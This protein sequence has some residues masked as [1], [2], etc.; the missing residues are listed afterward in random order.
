MTTVN[1]TATKKLRTAVVVVLDHPRF[2]ERRFGFS[3]RVVTTGGRA[4]VGTRDGKIVRPAASPTRKRLESPG[5]V[6][7]MPGGVLEGLPAEFERCTQVAGLLASGM[8][9]ISRVDSDDGERQQ[10]VTRT[11]GGARRRASMPAKAPSTDEP[12]EPDSE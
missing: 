2:R 5:S 8:I 11:R 12:G 1:V 10:S 9:T 4:A 6:T 3:R 7:I